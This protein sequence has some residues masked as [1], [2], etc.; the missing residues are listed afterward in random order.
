MRNLVVQFPERGRAEIV[1]LGEPR[2]LQPTEILVETKFS[3][4]TNGTERH[5]MMAE[6]FWGAFPGQHG[7][8]HVGT[9]VEAGAEAASFGV[10]DWVFLGDYVGHRG[11][12]IVDTAS[13]HLCI[14]L[15]ESAHYTNY[16]LMGVAGVAMKAVRRLGVKPADKVLVTGI[17]PIGYFAAIAAGVHGAEVTAADLNE[18]RLAVA[19]E[20]GCAHTVVASAPDYWQKLKD[21]GK[22]NYI[23]DGSGYGNL[24]YDIFQHGMLA[25]DGAICPL[26]VRTDTQFP[27]SMLHQ[28]DGRIEVS[29]HFGQDD[30]R[31]LVWCISRG[32]I[33]PGAIVSHTVGI[34]E[35]PGIYDIMRDSPSDLFGV[36]F[37][38][39]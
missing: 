19:A 3:G 21:L 1:D 33:D 38:W 20:Q 30:L 37:D 36:V 39:A 31:V 29:C 8:Q 34:Q 24:F 15:P 4:I 5:A 23:I 10:G 18:Q 9:V 12:N 26:A 17:G 25:H 13:S 35:A 2:Q 22:F 28:T 11:W 7:Y 27:W 16:S 6:H 32:V 14:R